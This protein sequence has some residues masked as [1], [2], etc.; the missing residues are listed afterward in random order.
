[1]E[2]YSVSVHL[3]GYLKGIENLK[4]LQEYLDIKGS[5]ESVKDNVSEKNN[6]EIKEI[7]EVAEGKRQIE[8]NTD[9]E[10]KDEKRFMKVL[11]IIKSYP[12]L[13]ELS[14][15]LIKV[16]EFIITVTKQTP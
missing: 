2:I 14:A 13:K 9:I 15:D 11:T 16:A 12:A 10:N 6:D 1:M 7:I 8:T 4:N 3:E 5:F